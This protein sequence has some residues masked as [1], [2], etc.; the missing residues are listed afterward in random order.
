MKTFKQL[1]ERRS[2][3]IGHYHNMYEMIWTTVEE[4]KPPSF[5]CIQFTN[6]RKF[7]LNPKN[8]YNTPTG[9]YAYPLVKTMKRD[10][11]FMAKTIV[12]DENTNHITS[13]Y[14]NSE[15]FPYATDRK[16]VNVFTIKSNARLL[17]TSK[18]MSESQL[19]NDMDKLSQYVMDK[20]S[21]VKQAEYLKE[22]GK[23]IWRIKSSTKLKNDLCAEKSARCKS[24]IGA[25][26][27][28]MYDF[29]QKFEIKFK[30]T[31][32]WTKMFLH[33]KYDGVVDDTGSGL[34]FT[35][36]PIQAVFF[37]LGALEF[38]Y[39]IDQTARNSDEAHTSSEVDAF[40]SEHPYLTVE[41]KLLDRNYSYELSGLIPYIQSGKPLNKKENIHLSAVGNTMKIGNIEYDGATI[42][43]PFS[44]KGS[45]E[46]TGSTI[47]NSYFD[48]SNGFIF[49]SI[50]TFETVEH[51][52]FLSSKLDPRK[53]LYFRIGRG[54]SGPIFD[55]CNFQFLC[56]LMC[57]YNTSVTKTHFDNCF[58]AINLIDKINFS[59]C[60]FTIN[61]TI[62]AASNRTMFHYKNCVL[63]YV[64]VETGNHIFMNC[65]L[66]NSEFDMSKIKELTIFGQHIKN[67]KFVGSPPKPNEK[68]IVINGTAYTKNEAQEKYK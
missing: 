4:T 9:I 48:F 3:Q 22:D 25:L 34:V 38:K 18:D 64:S 31:S 36:E 19:K 60:K 10:F 33:L 17:L 6:M 66:E 5:V 20:Y 35:A 62:K 11:I 13:T 52:T 44:N 54:L 53:I 56:V 68:N 2:S 12:A 1:L 32:V 49:N 41:P 16:F 7:G 65:I 14:A 23:W 55:R 59:D 47:K 24:N 61:T 26:W 42:K 51:S 63:N 57:N 58:V 67:C 50:G 21:Y 8:A 39:R 43:L 30:R 45:V 15:L 27:Y 46:L 29:L 28:Y 37:R 40:L